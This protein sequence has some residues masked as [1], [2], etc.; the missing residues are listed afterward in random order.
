MKAQLPTHFLDDLF[1]DNLDHFDRDLFQDFF[2][3]NSNCLWPWHPQQ[4]IKVEAEI[5]CCANAYIPRGRRT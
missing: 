5:L 3:Y 1:L 2:L 4:Q